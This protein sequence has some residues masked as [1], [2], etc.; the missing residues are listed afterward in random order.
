MDYILYFLY[1]NIGMAVLFLYLLE[2]TWRDYL[3]IMNLKYKRKEG[4]LSKQAEKLAIRI[5]IKGYI[6]DILL[7]L[8]SSYWLLDFPRELLFTNKMIRLKRDPRWR[9]QQDIAIQICWEMLDPFDNG[10]HCKDPQ[11]EQ[12]I[13]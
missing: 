6:R 5:V 1:F 13:V 3:A 12:E 7:N 2:S 4:K 8:V 10:C 11:A 9:W